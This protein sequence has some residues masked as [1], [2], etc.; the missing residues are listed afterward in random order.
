[1]PELY[2]SVLPDLNCV[3][4]YLNEIHLYELAERGR[5]ELPVVFTH[6]RFPGVRI[7]PLCHLSAEGACNLRQFPR[8]RKIFGGDRWQP[9]ADAI[10]LRPIPTIMTNICV[11]CPSSLLLNSA[12]Y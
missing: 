8:W 4:K 9:Q 6:S 11:A 2:A 5:F 1:M 12:G 10:R 3:A 7:K